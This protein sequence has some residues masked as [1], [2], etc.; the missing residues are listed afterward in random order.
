MK[1]VTWLRYMPLAYLACVR[2]LFVGGYYYLTNNL[3]YYQMYETRLGGYKLGFVLITRKAE[4][5]M[6][7][8]IP[9]EQIMKEWECD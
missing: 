6:G 9:L 1:I 8:G 2:W 4:M 3:Y 7:K 5:K